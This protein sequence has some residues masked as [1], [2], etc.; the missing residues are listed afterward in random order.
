MYPAKSTSNSPKHVQTCPTVQN[1]IRK[2]IVDLKKSG[3]GFRNIA[4]QLEAEGLAKISRST[5]ENIWKQTQNPT[6]STAKNPFNNPKLNAL[7]K[8][9]AKLQNKVT[10]DQMVEEAHQRIQDLQIHR[11]ENPKDLENIFK[12]KK[13]LKEFTLQTLYD[14]QVLKAFKLRCKAKHLPLS[15]AIAK[16]A[17]SFDEFVA[18]Q[19]GIMG[20][21]NLAGYIEE[22]LENNLPFV[23]G[24]EEEEEQLRVKRN[25]NDFM[26][27]LKCSNCGSSIEKFLINFNQLVCK[28]CQASYEIPCPRCKAGLRVNETGDYVKEHRCPSC[29]LKIKTTE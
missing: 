29:K 20:E 13:E 21:L 27:R 11:S 3:M 14:S 26:A 8:Q 18:Q 28:N 25:L 4:K 15:E 19:E 12:T 1:L 7:S 22:R 24:R 9:E 2:R 6:K 16:A 23:M 17:G 5:V 10:T